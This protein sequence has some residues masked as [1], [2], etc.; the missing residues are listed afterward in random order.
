MPLSW[1][2]FWEDY[3]SALSGKKP[4]NDVQPVNKTGK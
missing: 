2:S 1:Q 3:G 4:Q